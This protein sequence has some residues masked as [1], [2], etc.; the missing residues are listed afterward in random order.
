MPDENINQ[1]R[2]NP[3]LRERSPEPFAQTVR[4]KEVGES[5]LLDVGSQ[6]GA[7]R[8]LGEYWIVRRVRDHFAVLPEQ[9][10]AAA[11]GVSAFVS[12]CVLI[13]A[14]VKWRQGEGG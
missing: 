1:I 9:G 6:R 11:A 5:A 14:V 12:L 10:I 8:A 4:G 2:L 7:G 3:R 13:D